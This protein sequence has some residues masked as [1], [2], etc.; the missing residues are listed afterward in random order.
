MEKGSGHPGRP[1]AALRLL[2]HSRPGSGAC[3]TLAA[4]SLFSLPVSHSKALGEGQAPNPCVD[5][6][7]GWCSFSLLENSVTQQ[8]P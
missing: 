1:L 7:K 6:A 2:L 3:L 5:L 4:G 8:I